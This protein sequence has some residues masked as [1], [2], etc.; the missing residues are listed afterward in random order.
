MNFLVTGLN[1]NTAPVDIRE[2]VAM[3]GEVLPEALQELSLQP[4]VNEAM[5]VSTC[6]RVELV[7]S[8][9]EPQPN[10]VEFF[11]K[12]F[13]CA[14]ELP[15]HLYHHQET[16]AVRHLFRIASSLDSMVVGEP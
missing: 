2:Q 7:V 1:H 11:S 4:G 3:T 16:E 8:C 12:R 5:I 9:G 14:A 6:N 10:L 15:A 13:P